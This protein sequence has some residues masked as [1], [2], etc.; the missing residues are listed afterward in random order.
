MLQ[1][2]LVKKQKNIPEKIKFYNQYDH[3]Y[4]GQYQ[5]G[6][7]YICSKIFDNDPFYQFRTEKIYCFFNNEDIKILKFQIK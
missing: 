1:F 5:T 7:C 6:K 2:Y 3:C 4:K